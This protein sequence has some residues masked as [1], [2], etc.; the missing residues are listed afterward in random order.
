M[1]CMKNNATHYELV[2][3]YISALAN[4]SYSHSKNIIATDLS[5][6]LGNLRPWFDAP[7]MFWS[8]YIC[9]KVRCG[10]LSP[11]HKR[12]V[13][14]YVPLRETAFRRTPEAQ[15]YWL[16]IKASM[17]WL[18]CNGP[19]NLVTFSKLSLLLQQNLNYCVIPGSVLVD[20]PG[21]FFGDYTT[22]VEYGSRRIPTYKSELVQDL[23]YEKNGDVDP[24]TQKVFPIYYRLDTFK[25]VR[26]PRNYFRQIVG[27]FLWKLQNGCCSPCGVN[28]QY[29]FDEME[30]DHVIPLKLGGNN[31]L[32]NLEMKCREHNNQKR[33]RLSET[34]DY[35][36]ILESI[37][38]P[39]EIQN[40][41]V[42][43]IFGMR[44]IGGESPFPFSYT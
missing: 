27:R 31:T 28:L 3:R 8:D 42:S 24:L 4:A 1:S 43:R 41:L 32:L 14:R 25:P 33:A 7:M 26:Q 11:A 34:Q 40:P 35:K 36:L 16:Q 6:Y 15:E 10:L 39:S 19:Y 29:N 18:L 30:I 44:S 13:V 17:H 5:L 12:G 2:A 37:V 20:S 23:L 9:Y 38:G 22:N 21:V